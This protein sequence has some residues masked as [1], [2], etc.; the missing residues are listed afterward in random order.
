MH[1]HMEFDLE[2]LP[3]VSRSGDVQDRLSAELGVGIVDADAVPALEE[4]ALEGY[5]HHLHSAGV[6][7]CRPASVLVLPI[8]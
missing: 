8:H 2:A 7:A 6:R 3:A 5:L 1:E 4:R